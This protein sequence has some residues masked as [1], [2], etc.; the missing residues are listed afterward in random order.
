MPR[1]PWP[2]FVL[3]A[4]AAVVALTIETR[5]LAEQIGRG[6]IEAREQGRRLDELLRDRDAARAAEAASA[7][8]AAR[9]EREL[10]ASHQRLEGIQEVVRER[11]ELL[12]QAAVASQRR[13][14]ELLEPIP[15][16]VR[17]CLQALHQYLRSEG[18][19]QQRFLSAKRLDGDGL[20]DVEMI[21]TSADGLST[22]FFQA[23]RCS[24][25]LDR[26]AGRLEL[27]FFDGTKTEHGEAVALPEDGWVVAFAP[28]DGHVVETRLPSAS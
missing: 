7:A 26:A 10:F 17:Q 18:F 14:A 13:S 2:L 22:A 1:W 24:A 23:G 9:L 6:E 27:R 12:E 25:L 19:T 11:T 3:L 5:S 21:E 16:G 4:V 28:I 8:E 20:H 15:E